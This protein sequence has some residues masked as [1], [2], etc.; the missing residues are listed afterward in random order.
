M[1]NGIAIP[2]GHVDTIQRLADNVAELLK[3][4][5][6]PAGWLDGEKLADDILEELSPVIDKL[7]GV[8]TE[9][10]EATITY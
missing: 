6:D 8:Y 1:Y 7:D 2:Q 10:Q 9:L 3:I 5:N 4:W